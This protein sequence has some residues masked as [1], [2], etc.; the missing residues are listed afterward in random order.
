MA[1][2]VPV[3]L[4]LRAPL[5][6]LRC[7]LTV[8]AAVSSALSLS[9]P[10]SSSLS[11]RCPYCLSFCLPHWSGNAHPRNIQAIQHRLQ[12]IP[13]TPAKGAATPEDHPW[14]TSGTAKSEDGQPTVTASIVPLTI[15]RPSRSPGTP[16]RRQAPPAGPLPKDVS[17]LSQGTFRR[18]GRSDQRHPSP[19]KTQETAT[20]PLQSFAAQPGLAEFQ[21]LRERRMRRMVYACA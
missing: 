17:F 2:F 18:H 3:S 11:P 19:N 14:R 21:W 12:G 5:S 13:A 1:A 20:N 9:R 10:R 8:A 16:S 7:S 15:G 6:L 4:L